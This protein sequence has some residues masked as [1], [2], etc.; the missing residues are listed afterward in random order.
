MRAPLPRRYLAARVCE[1][2]SQCHQQIQFGDNI[3]PA[4]RGWI[5]AS[6]DAERDELSHVLGWLE[7]AVRQTRTPVLHRPE[8]ELLA[9]A[10][11][12]RGV[13][14]RRCG[15]RG[16]WHPEGRRIAWVAQ[17]FN[18]NAHGLLLDALEHG[19]SPRLPRPALQALVELLWP[20]DDAP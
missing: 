5:C 10:M 17:P 4:R 19:F 20:D 12:E 9:D 15:D 6:C 18:A 1:P 16:D 7:L 8:V 3:A 13:A 2:C 11:Q 14:A